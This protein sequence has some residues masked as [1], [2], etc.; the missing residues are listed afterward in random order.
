MGSNCNINTIIS[1]FFSSV[2]ICFSSLQ[3]FPSSQAASYLTPHQS[4]AASN[5]L[6][7]D[8]GIF[9]LGFFSLGSSNKTYVGIWYCNSGGS[10][11]I[12]VANRDSPIYDSSG[13][14][15]IAGDGNLILLDSNNTILW[16]SNISSISNTNVTAQLL[17][18]GNLML[19]NPS[20]KLWQSFDQP[21]D[22]YLPGM[23]VGLDLQTNK[24]QLLTSWRSTDDPA[25]GNFSLGLD[26]RR[27]T[28]L[29]MWE[30]KMP[31]W[32]SGIWK[33]QVFIGVENMIYA[34][35]Y[36]F[37]LS[38]IDEEQKMYYYI[39]SNSSQYWVLTPE[40]ILRHFRWDREDSWRQFWA[41]PVA[42]CDDY[43]KCGNNGRCD[44]GK[45][46]IC[47]CLNGFVPRSSSQWESGNW[48]GGCVRRTKLDCHRNESIGG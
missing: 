16:S 39:H 43:N 4:L 29:F 38:D 40:G 5:T 27:S 30:S 9:E 33:G 23:M 25:P 42:A 18:T 34:Y 8:G 2:L 48:T 10:R 26:P 13:S 12:W 35:F 47:G 45:R 22:T 3:L 24:N 20:G 1:I 37:K 46:P 32:R 6:V 41:A 7:S 17:D 31:Q 21:T 44:N 15:A 11:I 19:G 36:G 28:Q 14:L